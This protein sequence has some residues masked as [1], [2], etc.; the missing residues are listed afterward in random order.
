[1]PIVRID[2]HAGKSTA[3]KRALLHGVRE[4]IT[5]ALG[6]PEERVMQR[7]AESV[8]E[9]IDT[10]GRSSNRLT[11]VDVTMLP[12]RDAERKRSLYDALVARLGMEPGIDAADIMVV[13]HDPPAECFCLGGQMPEV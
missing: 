10:P 13:V 12:G 1:M 2:I 7:I 3:Y 6:V 8:P 4:A 5:I 11:I 9:D